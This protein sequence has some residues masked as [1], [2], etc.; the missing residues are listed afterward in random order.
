M[1]SQVKLCHPSQ[2]PLFLETIRYLIR[3][4]GVF[5][6]V[7]SL[8]VVIAVD[9]FLKYAEIYICTWKLSHGIL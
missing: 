8:V 4:C 1:A 6:S 5:H 9:V 2:I 3:E 7:F